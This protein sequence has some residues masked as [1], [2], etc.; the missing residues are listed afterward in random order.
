MADK[1][2]VDGNDL[3]AIA[4]FR[5]CLGRMTYIVQDCA[6][7]LVRTWPAMPD[8][9]KAQIQRELEEAFKRDDADRAAGRQHKE[10][11]WDCDRREWERVRKLWKEPS[12][13]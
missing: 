4:A 7:W 12:N 10:L 9:T 3:M 2:T 11:G 6:H 13:G 1:S 8:R 5:Y